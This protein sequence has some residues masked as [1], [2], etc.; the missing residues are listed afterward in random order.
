MLFAL[1]MYKCLQIH[2]KSIMIFTAKLLS[3]KCMRMYFLRLETDIFWNLLEILLSIA[4]LIGKLIQIKIAFN[5]WK[6]NSAFFCVRNLTSGVPQIIAAEGEHSASRA[7][8]QAA[9][10]IGTSPVPVQ[11]CRD[12]SDWTSLCF[13]CTWLNYY[14]NFRVFEIT[15][16]IRNFKNIEFQ[17][18][19]FFRTCMYPKPWSFNLWIKR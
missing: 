17:V 8:K 14:H 15:W 12:S 4:N 18:L 2:T 9:N 6:K 10:V 3:L 1:F 19:S 11:V 7:L 16:N 13:L 5:K